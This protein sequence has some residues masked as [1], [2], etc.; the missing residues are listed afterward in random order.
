MQRNGD[1]VV[2]SAT[3]LS[4][5]LN[6]RHLTGL[7]LAAAHGTLTRP[8]YEDPL[9]DLLFKRGLA[10]EQA[11]VDSLAAGGRTVVDLR[12]HQPA[13]QDTIARTLEAMRAGSELIVQGA[14]GDERW[15]GYPDI[16]QRVDGP[17]ALG[18][19]SYEVVDTK[20]ARTTK[21]GMIL[22]L[23]LYSELLSQVLG[24]PPERFHIV[25]PDPVTPQQSFRFEDYA[26][27]FRLV[28]RQLLATVA[29]GAGTAMAD[30]YPEP[31]EHCVVC[32][33]SAV[34][35]DKRRQDDHLS[36]VA[37][38]SRTQRRELEGRGVGTLTAAAG[39]PLPINFK[40]DRGSRES[41]ARVRE[42]A[43]VQFES[44]GREPPIHELLDWKVG[45]GL[46]RLPEPSP[47]D[48]FLD[49][50]GDPFACEGGREYLFGLVTHGTD[51]STR[52]QPF[53]A[54]TEAEERSAFE[55]TIDQI[56]AA[57][58][59]FPEMH[60]YHYA[61]YE[62]AA[63]KRLMGRH[64][65]RGDQLDQLLRGE[66][67]VDLYGVIRQGLRAG[68]E[69]YSIKNMEP[70]YHFE[71][72]VPL[73][74][75]NRFLQAMEVALELGGAA[76]LADEVRAGVAGYNED[77]CVSTLR[78]RD[79]LE[80]LRAEAIAGGREIPRPVIKDGEPP[81][82]VDERAQRVETLRGQLLVGIPAERAD[83][84]EEQE[85]RWILAYL[86][87][88]HRREDRAAWWEYFR[89]R[90]LP[91]DELFDERKALAG[92]EFVD[93]VDLKRNKR[94]NKPTGSVIDRYRYPV[95]EMEVG[96]GED[97][98]RQDGTRIGVVKAV[99]RDARTVD[100][101]KGPSQADQHP[102]AA[103]AHEHFNT[104]TMENTIFA[105]GER[106]AADGGVVVDAGKANRAG[107]DLLLRGRPRLLT[108]L[109]DGSRVD[110][111]SAAATALDLDDSVLALQGPPG[112]GKTYCGARMILAAVR[113]GRKVG[114]IAGSHKVIENLLAAV[115]A[116][117]SELK[118]DIAIGHKCDDDDDDPATDAGPIQPFTNNGEALAALQE[119]RI[120]VL[121]G[122]VW[123]WARE[124]FRDAADLLFVDEAGQISLANTIA[125]SNGARN[126]ILLGDP[127]QLDQPIKGTHPE[128][129]ASSALEHIL[130]GHQT[131]PPDRG[132]FLGVT[133]RLSPAICAYTS[134][135]FYERKLESLSGLERQV[136]SGVSAFNGSGLWVVD[137]QHDGNR[138]YSDEEIDAVERL[139]AELTVPG[140]G[141]TDAAGETRPLAGDGILVVAPY[142]AQVGRLTDRLAG[143]GA[144]VGTV[145]KFQGQEAPVVIYSMATSRAE[146]APRGM[147]FLYS[148]NRLNVA[149]SRARC[150]AIV[151]ASPRLYEP[152][153]RSPRQMALANALCRFREMAGLR[154][155]PSPTQGPL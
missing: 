135:V 7:D 55:A 124:E 87:D 102:Q 24:H 128:G 109:F 100:I 48:V 79:W 155:D 21:A 136:L 62:P 96:P 9:R 39:I 61:P 47:G 16:L 144:R 150:A 154:T 6:C 94:T 151:V 101:E 17:S 118:V 46:S 133:R 145:D 26:A 82:K 3:D 125:A 12:P 53:W 108:T 50:E 146:D 70:L 10:H 19:W 64:A 1:T 43:R 27:Y 76:G 142:N 99:D 41:Y 37:G 71:R 113:A 54:F 80:V 149:T 45:F 38:V 30:N 59:Q 88:W 11:H 81:A 98:K 34:C 131:M 91:E 72:Q 117:A 52:Y 73:R 18:A 14:L 74:E 107:R 112:S 95:Q 58:A 67:F 23:C 20:L 69:R 15:F 25:T 134:E 116:A 83:W 86:L 143:T 132:L 13:R 44:R 123:M 31:V 56:M 126:L 92:L 120:A 89:L 104:G 122:T 93:R 63:F 141:W 121:G 105:I 5:F 22:Q 57:L 60:V 65:T 32:A 97:L 137:V 139:V 153:C 8:H 35:R 110:L 49:L 84:S 85:A 106:V 77:D 103:F 111:D 119:G 66:R 140:A 40:P 51:G 36:L 78:L 115:A 29:R 2:L 129:A 130:G 90:A 68:V 4:R 138:N 42:Q 152:E 148:P 28:Q 75:A 114:V 33:W 127:Q 147:E